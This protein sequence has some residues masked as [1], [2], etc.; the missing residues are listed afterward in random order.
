MGDNGGTT[1]EIYPLPINLT[2]NGLGYMFGDFL[3]T[4]LV[5]LAGVNVMITL[6]GDFCQF[7]A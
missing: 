1:A 6:L 2:K 4:H 5:T 3:Q 7:S